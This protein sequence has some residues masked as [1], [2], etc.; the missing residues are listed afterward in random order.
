MY[1]ENEQAW[2]TE[3]KTMLWHIEI[4][5]QFRKRSK[6]YLRGAAYSSVLKVS[7]LH[8]FKKTMTDEKAK[9]VSQIL[10]VIYWIWWR[11][12]KKKTVII[13]TLPLLY[14][15]ITSTGILCKQNP[16]QKKNSTGLQLNW[17]ICGSLG[18]HMAHS[19][20]LMTL[21]WSGLW[22]IWSLTWEY[23]LYE[24]L[25]HQRAPCTFSHIL[26]WGQFTYWHVSGR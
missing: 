5:S 24:M 23:T 25:V 16:Q 7:D 9:V 4:N 1:I 8:T 22:W 11:H 14:K 19:L 15:V 17:Y 20:S 13:N 12:K 18:N 21:F 6:T 2:S 10:S 3:L 26:S